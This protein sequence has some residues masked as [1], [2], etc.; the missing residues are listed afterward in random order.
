MLKCVQSNVT[1]SD[2]ECYTGPLLG[3]K[4]VIQSDLGP[5]LEHTKCY[6]HNYCHSVPQVHWGDTRHLAGPS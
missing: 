5:T 3:T 2:T 4:N 1:H 6:T